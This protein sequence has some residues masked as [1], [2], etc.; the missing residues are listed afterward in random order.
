[1]QADFRYLRRMLEETHP[2]LYRY[3]PRPVMQAKLDSIDRSLN[4]PLP[5]YT[6]FKTVASLMADIR[7]AHTH[8]LPGKNWRE[9]FNHTLKTIPF[10]MFPSQNRAYVL[11]N[12]IT[13]QTI[14]PGFELLSINGQPME[15]IRQQ[16]SRY[17]WTD[18]YIESAKMATLKGELFALFYYW[19]IDRPDTFALTFRSPTGDTLRVE[20]PAKPFQTSLQL[21]K[22]NPVNKQMVAW[23]VTKN[24][25]HPW[26]LYFP[27]TLASTAYLRLDGFGSKGVNSNEEAVRVFRQFMDKS[28]AKIQKKQAKNMIVDVRANTGGWD[29]QGIELLTYLLKADTA[30]AYYARQ[31]SVTDDADAEFMKFSDLSEADRKNIKNEL[32]PEPDGTFTLKQGSD[33]RAPK[34]YVPKPNRFRG[35][36]YI[37]MDGASASTASEFLAVAHANRVGVFVGEESGGAY[38]GGNGSSFINLELPK[39]GIQVSTPLVYYNN[40]VPE[41]KQKGRGTMPDYFVPLTISNVLNH[42]APHVTFVKELIRKQNK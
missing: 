22:Q 29:S 41:L 42:T 36:V 6:F 16:V 24:S 4:K 20:T 40:A 38:E 3:T 31:H 21:M 25:K 14:K 33:T 11:L 28:M 12:G 10:F 17:Y 15:A 23:Y 7:C 35:Q 18:G 30:V 26:R 1:M 32:I 39:S 19:F 9:Q 8:A 5:F 2:G 34:R 27:D 37:L 13:D